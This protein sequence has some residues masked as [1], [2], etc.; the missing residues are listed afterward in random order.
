MPDTYQCNNC[1][2]TADSLDGWHFVVVGYFH[3]DGGQPPPGGKTLDAIQPDLVFHAVSCR[4]AWA[5]R[6]GIS[7]PAAAVPPP[8]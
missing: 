5:A 6:A 4:D 2:V 8:A 3:V 1:D 7:P